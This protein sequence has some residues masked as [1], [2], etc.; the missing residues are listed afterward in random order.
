LFGIKNKDKKQL[1]IPF[2]EVLGFYLLKNWIKFIVV[3]V[4][5]KAFVVFS[6]L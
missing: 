6:L 5:A 2:R 1:A 4:F 3:V